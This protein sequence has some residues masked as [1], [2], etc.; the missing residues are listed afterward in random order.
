M[1]LIILLFI[2]LLAFIGLVSFSGRFTSPRFLSGSSTTKMF[3]VY[4]IVLLCTASLSFVVPKGESYQGDYLTEQEMLQNERLNSDIYSIV[5]SGKIEEANGLSKKKSWEFPIEGEELNIESKSSNAMV[6]IEKAKSI[7]D[8][9]EVTHYSTF[10]YVDNID[11]TDRFT[12]P[13][14]ELIETTLKILPPDHVNIQLVK[15]TKAFPFTQFAE[16]GEQFNGR[17]GMTQGLNFIY[18]K[19]P[20]KMEVSGEGYVVNE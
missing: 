5:E 10:S 15:Y 11:I 13:E 19:V 6:F 12:S 14:V 4:I 3:T 18:I 7:A 1:S 17:N 8:K 16:D 2:L 9:I 20:G